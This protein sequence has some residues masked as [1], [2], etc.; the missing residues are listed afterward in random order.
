MKTDIFHPNL[1]DWEKASG[2][3]G[4]KIV[5]S[6]GKIR[7]VEYTVKTDR[8]ELDGKKLAFFSDLHWNDS[9]GDGAEISSAI[10]ENQPDWILFG[11]DLI[12]YMCNMDAAF[13]FLKKLKAKS[14]KLA[15]F[16]NW[17]RKTRRWFPAR[18]WD[19]LYAEAGFKLLVN[20]GVNDP[21]IFFCGLDD[22]KTGRPA[23]PEMNN[24]S[25]NVIFAHNPDSVPALA[26]EE[27]IAK[28]DLFLCGHTHA[29][30][31]RAPLFGALLTSSIYWKKFEYGRFVH[32][33][34]K[35]QIIVTSGIG[36]TGYPLR[37]FCHPEVAIIKLRSA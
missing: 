7:L 3:S 4:R 30:Q 29:G 19:S 5:A 18:I 15:V 32:R 23:F 20:S 13:D 22:F 24:D 16:G 6:Y 34:H 8:P 26:S 33:I 36:M 9:F 28:T 17:D 1:K 12:Q 10:N 37:L 25:F 14:R 27:N 21:G 2:Y 11:G 35:S 31:I